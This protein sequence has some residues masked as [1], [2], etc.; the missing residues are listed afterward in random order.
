MKATFSA[1]GDAK[2]C[3]WE[4]GN[5]ISKTQNRAKPFFNSFHFSLHKCKTAD[6]VDINGQF[7][8]HFYF[9]EDI[10]LFS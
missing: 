3:G 1:I 9:T 8:L 6:S 5:G 10:L 7:T 2:S 4:H